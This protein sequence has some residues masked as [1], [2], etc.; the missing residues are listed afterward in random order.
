MRNFWIINFRN[1]FKVKKCERFQRID[2]ANDLFKKLAEKDEAFKDLILDDDKKIKPKWEK[3]NKDYKWIEH[4][5][6]DK[7]SFFIEKIENW[8][9]DFIEWEYKDWNKEKKEPNTFDWKKKAKW[10]SLTEFYDY[11]K[12]NNRPEFRFD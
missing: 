11:I 8:K 7:E 3:W 12:D 5:I 4:F 9:I 10:W 1:T 2:D 6:W